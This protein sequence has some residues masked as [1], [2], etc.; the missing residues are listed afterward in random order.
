MR[1]FQSINREAG[2]RKETYAERSEGSCVC[3]GS[4]EWISKYAKSDG[5]HHVLSCD[6][7]MNSMVSRPTYTGNHL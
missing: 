2:E 3:I 4:N 7:I 5:S 6:S 1:A